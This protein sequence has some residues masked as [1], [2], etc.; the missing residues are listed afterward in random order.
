MGM[1]ADDAFVQAVAVANKYT[2][3]S[4]A[5]AGAIKGD[6]GDKGD[7]GPQGPAGP[8]GPAGA[9]GKDGLGVPSGGTTGQVLAKKSNADNDTEWTDASGGGTDAT[10]SHD[11]E[12]AVT[13]GGISD[14]T[15]YLTGTKLED[16]LSDM[17]SP[18]LYP[19]FTNPS[20]TIS[21]QGSKLLEKGAT[22]N[23]TI[24]LTFNRGT[25]SPAYGTSGY[26]SGAATAYALN[27]GEDQSENT[28]AVTVSESNKSFT[29]TVKYGAGEQPKD[30]KGNNYGEPLAAGSVNTSVLLYEFVEALWANTANITTVAKLALVS[31]STK[32]KTFKFPAQTVANPAIFDVP[33]SW[34]V[35]AVETLNPLSGQWDDCSSEF[36][37]SSTTHDDAS[38]TSVAYTRYT[39]NRGYAASARDVRIRWS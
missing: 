25:I 35:V 7:P 2:R 39:D 16:I 38:G 37:T 19:T 24:T 12:V 32:T 1:K 5:G 14:G 9:D 36:T 13:V 30:S 17:L 34:N 20:A 6:K 15:E 29:G 27:S 31:K 28:F 18:T 26:R 4:L 33:T 8:A 3:D 11:L 21:A 23:V 10:L 22:S